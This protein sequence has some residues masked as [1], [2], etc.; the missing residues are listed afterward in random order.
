M[1]KAGLFFNDTHVGT[2]IIPDDDSPT[3]NAIVQDR[4][5]YLYFSPDSDSE[6]IYKLLEGESLYYTHLKD[7]LFL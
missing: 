2:A 1:R 6:R 4:N 3:P 7:V 5:V